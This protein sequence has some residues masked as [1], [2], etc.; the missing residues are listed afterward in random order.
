MLHIIN[1]TFLELAVNFMGSLKNLRDAERIIW[2]H[3][4]R[5]RTAPENTLMAFRQSLDAGDAGIEFDVTLSADCKPVIIHDDTLERTTDGQGEVFNHDYATLM[6]LSAGSWFGPR[7][8]EE[9]LPRLYDVL[10]ELGERIYIN[11][12]IKSSAWRWE[13]SAGI[14]IKLMDIIKSF[15]I[16]DSML[17][18]SFNWLSLSRV[19]SLNRNIAIG[20]LVRRGWNSDIAVS[21]AEKIAAF[22]IHPN[23]T[24][25]AGGMPVPYI[26]FSGKIFPYTVGDADTGKRLLGTG[27][28]GFFADLPLQGTLT[29]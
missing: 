8:S 29:I 18:S 10:E 11:M 1:S 9:R 13:V 28:D 2:A 14:E 16:E 22:S 6:E 25:L 27:A 19:R 23:V 4:G 15:G 3:R 20:V 21:F 5:S 26:R 12:E 7:Y 17:I 24:D